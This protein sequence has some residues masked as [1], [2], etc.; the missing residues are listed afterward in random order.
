MYE[1]TLED[2][3]F[4]YNESETASLSHINLNIKE[5][6]VVVLCGESGF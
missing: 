1:I 3:S 2:V 5:G 4:H 6:S